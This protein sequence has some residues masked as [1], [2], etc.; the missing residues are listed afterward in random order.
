MSSSG[1]ENLMGAASSDDGFDYLFKIVLIG[2]CGTGKTC[3][4]QKFRSG[5]FIQRH[6]FTIGV[7]F[8]MKTVLVD[9]KRVKLQIWDT[10][11]Q[12]RFRTITQSYYRSANGVILV[13]DITKRST[14]LS[15]Q[16][17]IDEIR[18]YTSSHVLLILVGNKCDL[19]EAREVKSSEAETV[20]EYLPEVFR[21]VETSAKENTNIDSIFFCL[22]SELKRR[23]ENRQINT[24]ESG[25][26]KLGNGRNLSTCS[27]CSY[28]LS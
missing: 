21:N 14:F 4:V 27:M 19:E 18:R 9:G 26:V 5:N 6:G 15:L 25:T 22:A 13:Y 1:P 17:W 28:K 20:C 3:I 23:H 10:A 16:R 11:G 7:D 8:S 2:D 12:E 24:D